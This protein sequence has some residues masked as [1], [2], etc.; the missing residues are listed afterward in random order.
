MLMEI[1]HKK[2]LANPLTNIGKAGNL[3]LVLILTKS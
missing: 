3:I 2:N 1:S